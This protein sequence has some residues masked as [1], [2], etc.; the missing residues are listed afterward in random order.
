MDTPF[1]SKEMDALL[2]GMTV[3]ELRALAHVLE[4]P[5]SDD[6][7]QIGLLGSVYIF[8]FL[9]TGAIENLEQGIK[10]EER[11]TA[12]S[13]DHHDR[14]SSLNRLSHIWLRG[15]DAPTQRRI[16]NLQLAG[17]KDSESYTR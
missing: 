1:H 11:V 9:K 13:I 6:G 14:A 5:N 4:D 8:I 7:G 10:T 17:L 15:T 16:L 12:M 3:D 2:S